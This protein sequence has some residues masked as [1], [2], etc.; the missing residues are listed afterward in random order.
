MLQHPAY[1][2]ITIVLVERP[3]ETVLLSHAERFCN[4]TTMTCDYQEMSTT[5]HQR[6]SMPAEMFFRHDLNLIDTIYAS[7][8]SFVS[9]C[10]VNAV[11]VNLDDIASQPEQFLAGLGL[12][13]EN[14]DKATV[15][16]WCAK[17][18]HA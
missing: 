1:S 8:R 6:S 5:L 3:P 4:A 13:A 11:R 7:W 15:N 9:R 17:A 18:E 16:P 10:F 12:G 14:L 2:N